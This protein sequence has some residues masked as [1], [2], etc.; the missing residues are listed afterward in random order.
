M[1]RLPSILVVS[2]LGIV[3]LLSAPRASAQALLWEN[4]GQPEFTGA[5][6]DLDIGGDVVVSAGDVG[7]AF[8]AQWL[9]RGLDR[10]TGA[11]L[12]CPAYR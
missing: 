7:D 11:T 1:R 4:R 8:S 6:L 2:L 10:S 3:M 12:R 5:A 9:V